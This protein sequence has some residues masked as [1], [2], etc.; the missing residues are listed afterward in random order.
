MLPTAIHT[1]VK[2]AWN[3][4]DPPPGVRLVRRDSLAHA[5]SSRSMVQQRKSNA[6]HCLSARVW[7]QGSQAHHVLR[8]NDLETVNEDEAVGATAIE[9]APQ[10]LE[11]LNQQAPPAAT[12]TDPSDSTFPGWVCLHSAGGH[13]FSSA[14]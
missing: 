12:R 9:R 7:V 1:P 3:L 14:G 13:G 2:V 5:R 8:T 10:G 11:T 4:Q 6:S